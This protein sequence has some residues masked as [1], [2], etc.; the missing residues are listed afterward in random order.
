MS[1]IECTFK[2]FCGNKMEREYC[3][4]I[5]SISCSWQEPQP[6]WQNEGPTKTVSRFDG[7]QP[8]QDEIERDRIAK[9]N[10]IGM[11]LIEPDQS[12][13]LLTEI[14]VGALDAGYL[15][16]ADREPGGTGDSFY[17]DYEPLL[18]AQRDLTASIKDAEKNAEFGNWRAYDMAIAA[19]YTK[20]Q[21]EKAEA[22][23]AARIEALIEEIETLLLGKALKYESGNRI[24]WSVFSEI[25]TG[26]RNIK[27]THYKGEE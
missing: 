13:R 9:S 1:R 14:E 15:D 12:S 2:G 7:S 8:D 20:E 21:V 26:F 24:E 23:S 5:H 16:E 18:K 17:E 3:T 19:Q 6:N 4:N 22:K 11:G 25:L 10:A 27:A